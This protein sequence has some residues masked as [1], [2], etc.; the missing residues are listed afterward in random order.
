MIVSDTPMPMDAMDQISLHSAR[1]N[2]SPA[3]SPGMSRAKSHLKFE[4]ADVVHQYGY[5]THDGHTD[6]THF[7]RPHQNSIPFRN[8]LPPPIRQM[9]GEGHTVYPLRE[10]DEN[11][12]FA[13]K[14][15]VTTPTEY[16]EKTLRDFPPNSAPLEKTKPYFDPYAHER[17]SMVRDGSKTGLS[18]IFQFASGPDLSLKSRD[19]SRDREMTSSDT[20]GGAH[21]GTKDYPHLPKKEAQVEREERTALVSPNLDEDSDEAE[22][23]EVRSVVKGSVGAS[24]GGGGGGGRGRAVSGGGEGDLGTAGLRQLPVLPHFKQ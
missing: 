12:V 16:T 23:F 9:S 8:T 14:S 10:E 2:Q 19:K 20:R 24:K 5:T 21:R 3:P 1:L 17:P 6:A 7:S 22:P 11:P 18:S 4:E 13:S 15:L